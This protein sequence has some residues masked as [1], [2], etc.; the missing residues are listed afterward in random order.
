MRVRVL[1]DAVGSPSF[2]GRFSRP[3]RKAGAEVAAFLPARFRPWAPTF[4]FRN[5]RKILVVDGRVAYTGGM[6]V[7]REYETEWQD[8]S[9]ELRGPVVGQLADVFAEDW[10]FATGREPPA[11]PEVE[12]VDPEGHVCTV[13]ASG[14]DRSSNRVHD[15]FF[16]AITRA[17]ARVWIASPYFVPSQA[18]LAALRSAAQRGVD[19]RILTPRRSD[20]PLVAFASRSYYRPLLT[21]GVRIFEYTAGVL[22]AKALLVDEELSALGS[23]NVD[24]RSFRLNFEITCFV[25]SEALASSLARVFERDLALSEEIELAA[26]DERPTWVALAESMAH[27]LSPLL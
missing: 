5:H 10:C 19:V 13:V 11:L 1:V 3:L 18:L 22:H 20:L 7:G 12:A 16:L 9:L 14:P 15:A 26:L 8:L 25:A 24:A 23:T 17:R 27:L 2:G 21:E 4:N 6:N